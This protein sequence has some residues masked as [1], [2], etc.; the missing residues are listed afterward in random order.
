MPKQANGMLLW[1]AFGSHYDRP[2][3]MENI[4]LL[5]GTGMKNEI[6]SWEKKSGLSNY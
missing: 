1:A 6:I 5:A 2:W 3:L 4:K